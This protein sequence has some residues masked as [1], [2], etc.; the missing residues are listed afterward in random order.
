[1]PCRLVGAELD[2]VAGRRRRLDAQQV[3]LHAGADIH[4]QLPVA[5]RPGDLGVALQLEPLLD[6]E[7]ADD[8][9]VDD[10]VAATDRALDV[11]LRRQ[12]QQRRRLG[13]GVAADDVALDAAVDAHAAGERDVAGDLDAFGE[14]RGEL[15][16]LDERRLLLTSE[17]GAIPSVSAALAGLAKERQLVLRFGELL[18][19]RVDLTLELLA[20][21]LGDAQAQLG[22]LELLAKLLQLGVRRRGVADGDRRRLRAPK[23]AQR[24]TACERRGHEGHEGDEENDAAAVPRLRRER[25]ADPGEIVRRGAP[26]PGRHREGSAHRPA[27]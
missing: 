8:G 20:A 11:A 10:R 12:D 17:H 15:R 9:A 7:V 22:L 2:D 25:Q 27:R 4:L 5:D 14:E 18:A 6:V 21:R 24:R 13:I 3:P 23:L 16:H 19:E 1:V 26:E